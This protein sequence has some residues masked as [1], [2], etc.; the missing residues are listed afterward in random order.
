M[1]KVNKE[2]PIFAHPNISKVS[3]AMEPEFMYAGIS[4][5]RGGS[6]VPAEV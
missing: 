6:K 4:P 1:K 3:F 5:L 2:I